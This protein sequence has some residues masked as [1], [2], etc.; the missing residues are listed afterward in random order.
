MSLLVVIQWWEDWQLR[1]LVMGSL[2]LQFL[3]S[4]A[5]KVFNGRNSRVIRL[6]MWLSYLGADASAIYALATLFNR[7]SKNLLSPDGSTIEVLW[8][9][10]LLIHLGGQHPVTAY[11]IEDN[12][13]WRRHIVTLVSQVT[14]ALYV[15]IRSWPAGGDKRLLYAGIFLFVIGIV[16]LINK[17]KRLRHASFARLMMTAGESPS[18]RMAKI[19]RPRSSR[20]G[21]GTRAA[22]KKLQELHH[23]LSLEDYVSKAR[24]LATAAPKVSDVATDYFADIHLI[25]VD[26]SAPYPRRLTNLRNFLLATNQGRAYTDLSYSI[27]IAFF[28]IYTNY[29]LVFN[30]SLKR[31]VLSNLGLLWKLLSAFLTIPPLVLFATSHKDASKSPIDVRVTYMLLSSTIFL[32]FIYIIPGI[33]RFS[34]R[35]AQHNIVSLYTKKSS[36]WIMKLAEF[37]GWEEFISNHWPAEMRT[38]ELECTEVTDLVTQHIKY[39][40]TQYIRDGAS[41]KRFTCLRGEWALS[42]HKISDKII[43]S[44]LLQRPFDQSVVL[45]HLATELCL[46]HPRTSPAAEAQKPGRQSRI[47]SNYMIYLLSNH[48][49]LLMPGTRHGLFMAAYNGI[50]TM[51]K[52]FS[53]SQDLGTIARR[54]LRMA[55]FQ[56]AYNDAI[57]VGSLVPS[58]CELG[59]ALMEAVPDETER[60]NMI[61]DVWVEMLCYSASS[62]RG[63]LHAKSMGDGVQFLTIVW[64]LLSRMG[65]ETF[66]DKFQRPN[67]E[68][69]KSLDLDMPPIEELKSLYPY[70]L[71]IEELTT[72][73]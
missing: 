50:A 63:Y 9:P 20:G 73:V 30:H 36:T 59:E 62:C 33:H 21:R 4:L 35:I 3:L 41:Y 19:L 47:I 57:A 10:I 66:A 42:R 55:K 31:W 56:L 14:V 2:L 52:P 48:P 58:A 49:E 25:F 28:L 5:S 45:W 44:S 65:M 12:E 53:P 32:E 37:M 34:H 51:L 11:S 54:I 15:F 64:L 67:E 8:A 61:Q 22:M 70:L 27:L 71:P 72:G 17:P 18:S 16:K 38:S 69:I 43:W 23:D 13:L 39:G 46:H 26:R 1:I 68:I 40:W 60:W 6:C 24:D 7:H 29:K